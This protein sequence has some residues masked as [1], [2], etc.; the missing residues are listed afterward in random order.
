MVGAQQDEGKAFIV[1]QQHVVSG[2][3]TLDE[4]RLQQQRL[5]LTIGG[6]DGHGPRQRNHPAQAVG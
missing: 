6:D 2:A 4:L 5:S 3:V 1:A